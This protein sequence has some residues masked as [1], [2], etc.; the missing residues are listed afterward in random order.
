[1]CLDFVRNEQKT[2]VCYFKL[3]E[4][5]VSFHQDICSLNHCSFAFILKV[6]KAHC[7][8]FVDRK[9]IIL[10]YKRFVQG[11]ISKG[12]LTNFPEIFKG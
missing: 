1:M 2:L 10:F 4:L 12:K 11:Q 6:G 8:G 3:L 9:P 5:K 7:I